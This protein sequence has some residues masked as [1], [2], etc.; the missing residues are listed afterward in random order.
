MWNIRTTIRFARLRGDSRAKVWRTGLYL[1]T[2]RRFCAKFFRRHAKPCAIGHTSCRVRKAGLKSRPLPS[3]ASS[4]VLRTGEAA[5][6]FDAVIEVL[7]VE[8][9]A[10]G[11]VMAPFAEGNEYR[12]AGLGQRMGGGV[13]DEGFHSW[14]LELEL[15]S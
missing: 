3:A 10:R 11:G 4:N 6:L 5:R 2:A 14:S 13:E 9:L 12:L 1:A 8:P 7:R 15:E